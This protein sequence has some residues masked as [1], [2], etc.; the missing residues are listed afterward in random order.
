[1]LDLQNPEIFRAALENVQTGV[2]IVDQGGRISFWNGGA[3]A[4]LCIQ[5]DQL[6]ELMATRG[7]EAGETILN[8]VA[9]TLRHAVGPLDFVGRWSEDQF[10][11]IVADCNDADLLTTAER[12]KR[13]AESSEIA[14]WG[15]RLSA[16]VSVGGTVLIPGEPLASLLQRTAAALKSA[17]KMGGNFAVVLPP[18]AMF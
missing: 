9:H 14:W 18:P 3:E 2:C 5:L 11:A 12:L 16:T 17:V 7:L 1:M 10:L 4:L 8:V 6:H 13:L 15:D